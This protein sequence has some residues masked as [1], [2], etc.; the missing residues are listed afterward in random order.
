MA[1][2]QRT[3]QDHYLEIW[4]VEPG[5][6]GMR[7]DLF[8]KEKYRRL[9]REYIQRYI[10][11]GKVTINK[12]SGA[13]PSRILRVKDRISILSERKN[14]PEVDFDYQVLF[15][16]EHVLVVDKPGNLPVHP[17]GRYF[18]NTLL[19]QL[20]IVNGN[21]VEQD[22]NFY[23]VHRLDRETSGVLVMG[24]TAEATANL[25]RQFE[26]RVPQKEYLAIVKGWPEWEAQEIDAPLAKD[27]HAEIKLKMH[28]AELGPDGAPLFLPASELLPAKT[29]V[30]VVE[31][32]GGAGGH[33]KYAVVRC[34]PHTGRQ[35]Q[36]RVHL[37]HVGHPIIGDKLYG[38]E[39]DIFLKNIMT[40]ISIEVE[41]GLRLSRHALHAARLRFKHP[42]TGEMM[43][44]E[45]TFPEELEEFLAEVRK[46]N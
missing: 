38:V 14:E 12:E 34:K 39:S 4:T 31:R 20:R 29:H 27:P 2:E 8:L 23:I 37:A 13:K 10:K 19:M 3:H 15:E 18:F 7:L 1:K 5:E 35:H 22:K 42:A 30:E 36:I 40:T 43:E 16:D 11:D 45:S 33:G 41:P 21:E 6:A 32:V 17:S 26:T 25:V 9:S 44:V 46:A 28:V 24:K